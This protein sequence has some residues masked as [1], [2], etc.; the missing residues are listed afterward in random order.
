MKKEGVGKAAR[1]DRGLGKVSRGAPLGERARPS[2]F[3]FRLALLA[4]FFVR[5]I[6]H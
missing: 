2:D 3:F 5:P 1:A 4:D 6:L